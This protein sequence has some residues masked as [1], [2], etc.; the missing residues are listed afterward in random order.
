MN[1]TNLPS[2]ETISSVKG[3]LEQR[4]IKTHIVEKVEDALELIKSMIPEGTS[5]MNGS[6]TTL[7]EIGF[8]ELLKSKNHKWNNL[9]DAILEESD[10]SK[11]EALRQQSVFCDYFL[12][13][14]HAI[15]KDGQLIIASASGSQIP[16][17]ANTAKNVIFVAST[18][19]I[20][21]DLNEG[22]SR[23]KNHVFPLEDQRMKSTG[24]QGSVIAK[25]LIFEQE[26]AFTGRSINMILIKG[27]HGF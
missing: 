21:E 19:K 15:T 14:V 20:T 12:V 2:D 18:S 8:V 16:S 24:A 25:I 27:Q 6:S 4:N 17:I 1:Y 5:I 13:S 23:L 3:N 7:N 9:H 22:L 10:I 26:P 11:R